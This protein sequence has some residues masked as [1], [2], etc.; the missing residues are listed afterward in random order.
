[1]FVGGGDEPEEQLGTVVVEG[2]EADLVDQDEVGF[3]DGLDDPSD[4]V[5]GEAA[6]EGLDELS[7]GEVADPVTGVDGGVAERDEQVALAGA[8]GVARRSSPSA[9]RPGSSRRG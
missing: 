1:L 7:G 8:G 2:C 6:V 5:V 3:E 4:G 9:I